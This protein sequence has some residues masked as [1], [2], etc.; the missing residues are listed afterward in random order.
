MVLLNS[1]LLRSVILT[2]KT[3]KAK[4]IVSII[5]IVIICAICLGVFTCNKNSII[6]EWKIDSF[7]IDGETHP[8]SEFGE[9][10]GEANQEPMGYFSISFNKDNTAKVIMPTYNTE[11]PTEE[12]SCNY[13]IQKNVIALT[14]GTDSV[15]VF[16]ISKDT[17]Q[18]IDN[19]FLIEGCILK[20]Q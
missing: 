6:G 14:N 13:D 20:K 4:I 15:D 19:S 5:S 10:W 12:I 16:K 7:I 11:D 8:F 17:L 1:I 18:T 9:Y 3:K 2:M